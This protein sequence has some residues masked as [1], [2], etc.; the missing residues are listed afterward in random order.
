MTHRRCEWGIAVITDICRK[1]AMPARQRPRICLQLIDWAKG[2]ER[3]IMRYRTEITRGLPTGIAGRLGVR[4]AAIVVLVAIGSAT[5]SAQ[6]GREYR[7]TQDDQMA[8]IGDVF[9]LCSS[10]IPSVSRIVA[11]LVREKPQLTADCRAV[12][13]R[14]SP[15]TARS[16]RH[17]RIVSAARQDLSTQYPSSQYQSP[18]NQPPQ[19]QSPQYQSPQYQPPQYSSPQNQYPSRQY[20]YRGDGSR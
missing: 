19:Y 16:R 10:E 13:D 6:E 3:A 1:F 15:R 2:P 20:E 12:F 17:H 5:A 8:C 11:C 18:Q 9:R 7:G 4:R 14:D